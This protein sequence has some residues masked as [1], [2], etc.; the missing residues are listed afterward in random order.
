MGIGDIKGGRPRM[1]D[2]PDVMDKQIIKYFE[3]CEAKE[4]V[5]TTAGLAVFLGF[6]DRRSLYDYSTNV[7]FTL[8]IKKA[9]S[10]IE[11]IHE[12]RLSSGAPVGSIFWLKNHQWQDK[13]E[14]KIDAN[15][16]AAA[17]LAKR[18]DKQKTDE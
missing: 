12:R 8:V 13:T 5:P 6:C 2:D 16:E 9:I 15:E 14:I 3:E 1:Y 10:K 18:L 11:D 17:I 7:R 4:H